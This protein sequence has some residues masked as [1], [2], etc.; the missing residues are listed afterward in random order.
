MQFSDI[1][2]ATRIS[3]AQVNKVRNGELMMLKEGTMGN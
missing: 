2:S 3:I 1:V